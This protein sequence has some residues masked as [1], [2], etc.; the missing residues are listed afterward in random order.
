VRQQIVAQN[1]WDAAEAPSPPRS[2]A[3]ALGADEISQLVA[4]AAGTRWE[5][6][7]D[8]ALALGTRRGELLALTWDDVD[9]ENRRVT[10]WASLSQTAG[11]TAIESTK[12]GR[13]RNAC[14]FP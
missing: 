11:A 12:S 8:L 5:A 3:R 6:F 9:F 7:I 1:I 10:V 14:T 4:V 13:V 2:E